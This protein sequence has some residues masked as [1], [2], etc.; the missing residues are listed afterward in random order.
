MPVDR[1]VL[2]DQAAALERVA[3]LVDTEEWRADKRAAWSA[4]LRALAYRMDWETGL[5]T[6][7]TRDALA[8]LGG[9]G[10]RTVSA[11]L[12][13]AQHME[14][15]A[16]VETGAAGSFLGADVNRA[17][18]YVFTTPAETDPP[19]SAAPVDRSCNLPT[20][21]VRDLPL[22]SERLNS[23]RPLPNWPL[24]QVPTTGPERSAAA[25]TLAARIGLDPRRCPTWR[26]RA[27]LACW[28][29]Q[30]ASVAGLL[31]AV[32]HHPDHP[33]HPDQA[34]GD[35]LRGAHDLLRVLGH[36]LRPW[37]GRLAQLPARL[38]GLHGDYRT[39][40]AERVAAAAAAA[41]TRPLR[42]PASSS[43]A[44]R[45]A[46]RTELAN[47][48]GRPKRSVDGVRLVPTFRTSGL[49]Q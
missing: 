6:A 49:P 47:Q 8:R 43:P 19:S 30:G 48:L 36:R 31:H 45:A 1:T 39:A 18:T 40:Q 26:L 5:V 32:D 9:V 4:M 41:E 25:A 28:W 22:E 7:V 10:V 14:L 16:V 42:R 3:R 33:D 2:V 27:L 38:H 17:P 15:V 23:S 35:A 21:Y 37:Q 44:V 34:R 24:W 20:S 13:W 29:A 12:A 46:A 11:M